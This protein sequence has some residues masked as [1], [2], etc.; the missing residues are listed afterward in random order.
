MFTRIAVSEVGFAGTET[1]TL[2]VLQRAANCL[3]RK[4]KH[5]FEKHSIRRNTHVKFKGVGLENKTR[6]TGMTVGQDWE[7]RF[8][9]QDNK[10]ND[11]HKTMQCDYTIGQGNRTR[12]LHK[13]TTY[14]NGTR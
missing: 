11:Y 8:T 7:T 14:T 12:Q 1:I 5:L 9:A 10:G 13:M 2:T 6:Q 3:W 4:N